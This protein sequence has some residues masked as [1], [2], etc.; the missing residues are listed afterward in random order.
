[1]SRL[2][3]VEHLKVEL[4]KTGEELVHDISFSVDAGGSL[5]IL[6]QSGSG[7]TMTCRTVMGLLDRKRFR[8]EGSLSFEGRQLLNLG[9]REKSKIYGGAIAMIPQNPMTSM[10]PSMR[11]G[12]QMEETLRLHSDLQGKALD[13]KIDSALEEAGLSDT[14]V[15]RKSYPYMLSGGMLQRV[16]IAMAL[17]VNARLIVADE[18]TTALD[19]AH[20]NGTV[21][22]FIKF[23]EK[24]VGVLLVTHDFSVAARMGGRV[25]VMKD[26]GMVE[27]GEISEVLKHPR[28]EYTKALLEA[29]RLSE[30]S[31]RRKIGC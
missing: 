6:G 31:G 18:P 14:S 10:D 30:E 21:D 20:R 28:A 7:K 11:I 1:M 29:S 25:L 4:K 5:V 15:L 17:M 22:T 26:G 16:T 2:L 13:E 19:A 9:W 12:R 24:G 3:N 23:R 27:T 8:V